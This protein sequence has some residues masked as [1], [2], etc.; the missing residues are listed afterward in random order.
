MK[1]VFIGSGN[2]ATNLALALK[3][4]GENIVQVFSKQLVHAQQLADKL[5]CKAT[6]N[7]KELYADADAYIISI[8]DDAMPSV[9]S[10]IAKDTAINVKGT[11]AK[12]FIHTAGSVPMNIF[13][14]SMDNY[15][16][17]YPM[18]TFSK[19]RR[20]NFREIPCFI[21][22]N[23][24]CSMSVIK[25][26]ADDV[27]DSVVMADS[28]KRK[29]LHLAAVFACNMTNHCYRL[30]ERILEKEGLDFT[31]YTPLI[32]ETAEKV[33]TMSPKDA[34]TGP[35]VRY[36]TTVMNRQLDLIPD[37][38]TKNIYRLFA[39]SIHNETK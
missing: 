20:V 18:Q 24:E 36:D 22:S 19:D 12:V 38:T 23:N 34:Q 39:E 32:K 27:S 21:E 11:D 3:D 33:L 7:I 13:E 28:E 29:M 9:I 26:L 37:E 10:S 8:K 30:A 31:L 17:L 35:M 16:V 1:I 4:A 5:G 14:G 25:T 15:G 2:L 6:D